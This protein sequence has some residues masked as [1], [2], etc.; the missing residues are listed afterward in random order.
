MP[1]S[2]TVRKT[3]CAA[4]QVLRQAGAMFGMPKLSPRYQPQCLGL[5]CRTR[6]ASASV[7]RRIGRCSDEHKRQGNRR[8]LTIFMRGFVKFLLMLLAVANVVF[9]A[10][11]QSGAGAHS[12]Q[13]GDVHNSRSSLDWAGTYEGVLPCADCPGTKIRL[14][15]NGDGS[16]RLVTHA[17]GC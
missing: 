17:Q 13:D 14:T 10:A 4:P 7:R 8:P 15:L 5:L 2:F 16:Y 3:A 6:T 9:A 1:V 12:A 11:Q